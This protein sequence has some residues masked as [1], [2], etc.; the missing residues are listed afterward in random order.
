MVVPAVNDPTVQ[1]LITFPQI[2]SSALIYK[3]HKYE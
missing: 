1:L 2:L 3:Y